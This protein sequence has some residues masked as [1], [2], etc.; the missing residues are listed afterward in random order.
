MGDSGQC[1]A[2]A[3]FFHKNDPVPIIQEARWAPGP[4]WMGA[5]N[6]TLTGIRFPDRPPHS[7]S[8]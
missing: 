8:Q 2:L 6:L 4:A 3:V 1:D 5:G 7:Q